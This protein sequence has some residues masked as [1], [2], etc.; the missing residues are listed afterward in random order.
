MSEPSTYCFS[1]RKRFY[2]DLLLARAADDT[3]L[4]DAELST[5]AFALGRNATQPLA[6]SWQLPR[7]W[8]IGGEKSLFALR[9]HV[10]FG[11]LQDGGWQERRMAPVE[12]ALPLR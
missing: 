3:P 11:W 9:G 12:D 1:R 7:W 10:A 5:G 8:R 2:R 4:N 6:I